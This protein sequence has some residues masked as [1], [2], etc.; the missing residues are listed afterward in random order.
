MKPSRFQRRRLAVIHDGP[1]TDAVGD[2]VHIT[3]KKIPVALTGKFFVG[4][5]NYLLERIHGGIVIGSFEVSR[6]C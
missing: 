5:V 2:G 3:H 6:C 4:Q 1:F